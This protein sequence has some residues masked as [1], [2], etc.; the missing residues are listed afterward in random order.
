MSLSLQEPRDKKSRPPQGQRSQPLL[1]EAPEASSEDDRSQ[2]E[3]DPGLVAAASEGCSAESAL[4][5]Q[6]A[7]LEERLERLEVR[8]KELEKHVFSA[9]RIMESTE[10]LQ[11]YSGFQPNGLLMACFRFLWKSA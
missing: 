2:S 5:A 8:E 10:L 9:E 7:A 3:V 11:F 1:P 4:A 6:V